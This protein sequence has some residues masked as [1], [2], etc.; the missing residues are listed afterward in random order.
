MTAMNLEEDPISDVMAVKHLKENNDIYDR[1]AVNA[2]IA[3]IKLLPA[4]CSVDL[5]NGKK[6][7]VIEENPVDFM[8]P[9]VLDFGDNQTYD[10][11]RPEVAKDLHILDV[12]KTMDNRY[13]MTDK[14]EE[15]K[16]ALKD[17]KVN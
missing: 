9:L 11:S 10:L 7:L 1:S 12:M 6:G 5:S 16:K 15:Y 17:G 14:Y 4:G 3:T 2:L 8:H 13:I